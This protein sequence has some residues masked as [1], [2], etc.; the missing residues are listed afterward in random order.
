MQLDYVLQLAFWIMLLFK[1]KGITPTHF[2][3]TM[4]FSINTISF[5]HEANLRRWITVAY[6]ELEAALQASQAAIIYLHY[7]FTKGVKF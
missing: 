5:S 7:F 4:E 3:A 2:N 6:F 1:Q